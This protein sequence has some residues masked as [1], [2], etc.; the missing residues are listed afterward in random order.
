MIGVI[1]NSYFVN[2]EA[3]F[4]ILKL[5][6]CSR[7]LQKN[8]FNGILNNTLVNLFNYKKT[9]NKLPN[10]EAIRISFLPTE[11][12]SRAADEQ[13]IIEHVVEAIT[14]L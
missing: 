14:I 2:L 7:K 8:A 3:E 4:Y 5:F 11:S 10:K 12:S 6:V 9:R 13:E 1:Y